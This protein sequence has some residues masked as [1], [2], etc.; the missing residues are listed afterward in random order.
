MFRRYR[1]TRRSRCAWSAGRCSSAC[2]CA[3]GCWANRRLLMGRC[4]GR[5]SG[6]WP[7][8]C[9]WRK[10]CCTAL[11]GRVGEECPQ[12]HFAGA[13]LAVKQRMP[14]VHAASRRVCSACACKG[15]AHTSS[16][17][18]CSG[19]FGRHVCNDGAFAS[20]YAVPSLYDC[21]QVHSAHVPNTDASLSSCRY[22]EVP[23]STTC[24]LSPH[25]HPSHEQ[26]AL[27][28]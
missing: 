27:G 28:C 11:P 1:L 5:H 8:F 21:L 14:G 6:S 2:I 7:V 22:K 10:A 26:P 17:T 20:A 19:N 23:G 13:Q 15:G 4:L 24:T 16:V 18:H 3:S 9:C 12:P 25:K